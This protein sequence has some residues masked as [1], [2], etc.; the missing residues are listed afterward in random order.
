MKIKEKA[1]ADLGECIA[2]DQVPPH[3]VALY[4]KDKDFL[5]WYRKKYWKKSRG[6]KQ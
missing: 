5:K 2:S 6:M 4:F 1:Y 3:K